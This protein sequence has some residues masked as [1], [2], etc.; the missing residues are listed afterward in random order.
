MQSDTDGPVFLH[1]EQL[2]IQC[3]ASLAL[4]PTRFVVEILC[5]LRSAA[6]GSQ[7]PLRVSRGMIWNRCPDIQEEG[8]AIKAGSRSIYCQC[9][10]M[11]PAARETADRNTFG[12]LS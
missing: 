1:T 8:L 2:A 11:T 3:F 9:Q 6:F 5:C 12:Q 7:L 4:F 10:N